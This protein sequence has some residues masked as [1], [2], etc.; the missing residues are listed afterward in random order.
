MP[1]LRCIGSGRAAGVLV[2]L[3]VVLVFLFNN[4]GP[5]LATHRLQGAARKGADDSGYSAI[6]HR[7]QGQSGRGSPSNGAMSEESRRNDGEQLLA[8]EFARMCRELRIFAYPEGEDFPGRELRAPADYKYGA[9]QLFETLL[10]R[11][12]YRGIVTDNPDEAT[13]FYVPVHCTAYRFSVRDRAEGQQVAESTG[14]RV[15]A[16]IAENWPYWNA[17][18]GADHFYLCAHDMGASVAAQADPDL[19][20][21]A[22]ALVN[23]ADLAD[24][25]FVAHKDIALPPHVGDGCPTCTQ[26]SGMRPA[27]LPEQWPIPLDR[28]FLAFFAGTLNRGTVRPKLK[29][30][31][32]DDADIRLAEAILAPEHYHHMLLHSKF[33]L[34]PRGHR[35]WSPRLLDA[36]WFGCIPVIIADGY[37]LPQATVIPWSEMAVLLPERSLPSL[38]QL[39]SALASQSNALARKQALL[40]QYRHLLTWP[41]VAASNDV[42]DGELNA[43][44]ALL[45]ELWR[46]SRR[47]RLSL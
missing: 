3:V 47:G 32:T 28:P 39:L 6:H 41:R 15:I 16:H 11:R 20:H 21:N 34:V 14:R 9:E 13:L 40:A 43:L 19:L 22:I 45:I 44:D 33:C 18:H 26:G 42:D 46:R 27:P 36:V 2:I 31:F 10:L 8:A 4:D 7:S 17:S 12:R 37:S 5:L 23:T 30:L 38:K 35:V 24:P 25:F 29:S 1:L